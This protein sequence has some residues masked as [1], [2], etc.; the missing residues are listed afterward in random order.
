MQ[1]GKIIFSESRGTIPHS[2]PLLDDEEDFRAVMAVLNSGRLAQGEAVAALEEDFVRFLEP[3]HRELSGGND[4]PA[5]APAIAVSEL[6]AGKEFHPA[7]AARAGGAHD[8]YAGTGDAAGK[9]AKGPEEQ[10]PP[11]AP[12][13][14]AGSFGAVAVSSGTAALHLTLLALGIG[15][16]DE[17][18][19][20]SYACVAL[21]HAVRY[22][23]AEPVL[24]D[25]ETETFNIYAADVKRRRTVKTRAVIVPHLF[26]QSADLRELIALGIPVIEDC[27]Q[28]LGCCY[29]G[30][31]TGSWGTAA[32]FSF[33]ATKVIAAGE[34]GLIASRDARLIE[35]VRDLRD[36]DEKESLN[37]RFNYKLT[38]IQAALARSQFSK[39]PSLIDR[40]L[41]IARRYDHV[42]LG[43]GRE[44]PPRK[45]GRG[46]IFFRYVF[47][48][49]A[50]TT[51]LSAM[52]ERGVTCRRPVFRPLHHYLQRPGYEATEYIWEHAVS[53]PLYPGLS[54]EEIAAVAGALKSSL[55]VQ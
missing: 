35:K 36:Y 9:A 3:P 41:M 19:I 8:D 15:A 53:V 52:E 16:G 17:V 28:S 12:A 4:K 40:R 1:S 44:P 39:L 48:H 32:V 2:R 42:L 30:R 29:Q 31:P 18:I 50:A 11:T 27:A 37:L 47:L 5:S 43:A 24:A 22:T 25:S 26:G 20:P 21:W 45:D 46:H 55:P 7:P 38:D 54:E 6:P 23:G 33:Y 51:F 10:T 14:A 13:Q 34:G 49:D